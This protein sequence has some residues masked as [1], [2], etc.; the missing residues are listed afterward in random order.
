MS[1]SDLPPEPKSSDVTPE[2]LYDGR[3]EF[4]KNTILYLTTATA[5][6]G[7]LTYLTTRGRLGPGATGASNQPPLPGDTCVRC[8]GPGNVR[9]GKSQ[10][11]YRR[12]ADRLQRH[13]DVQ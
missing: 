2:A 10:L 8:D 11:R 5:I 6:G 9:G 3:R 7:G 4:I 12:T 13:F 1:K